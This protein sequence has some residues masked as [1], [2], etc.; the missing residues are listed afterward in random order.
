MKVGKYARH[1]AVLLETKSTPRIYSGSP[2]YFTQAKSQLSNIEG[3]TGN[4]VVPKKWAINSCSYQ[5][6]G[7]GMDLDSGN[8]LLMSNNI[9]SVSAST[10]IPICVNGELKFIQY[11]DVADAVRILQFKYAGLP[12]PS[13]DT[14]SLVFCTD[15]TRKPAMQLL[16][17]S[18][19]GLWY[20][21][22]NPTDAWR[23]V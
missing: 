11:Q 22:H 10:R 5:G 15:T 2:F 9:R 14:Y 8:L 16:Y 6:N 13:T 21:V 1:T 19:D 12:A 7:F 17:A 23:P 20:P 18:N 3:I 4:V